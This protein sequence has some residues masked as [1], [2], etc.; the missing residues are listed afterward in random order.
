[1][2][3]RDMRA[4]EF[5]HA[6]KLARTSTISRLFYDDNLRV[7]QRRLQ[8]MFDDHSIKRVKEKELI[9]YTRMP[10]QFNH[11]LAVTDYLCFL[12]RKHTLED[13]R[14]E[15]KCG[16]VRSDAFGM[17]NGRP[18]FIEVQLSGQADMLKY[19]S[20]RV[21]KV[22]QDYFEEFPDIRLYSTIAPKNCGIQVYV[23]YSFAVR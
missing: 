17:V 23:D 4:L 18:S 10:R 7:A 8:A 11:A 20:L 22:W 21:S 16:C 19:L 5:V 9:Y 14:A 6:F 1:M 13:L 2:T 12:S 3:A 15:Y